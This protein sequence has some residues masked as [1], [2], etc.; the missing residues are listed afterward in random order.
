M[1]QCVSETFLSLFIHNLGFCEFKSDRL[2]IST[3]IIQLQ[4]EKIQFY[5][6]ILI[7]IALINILSYF[8]VN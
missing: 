5:L 2:N 3:T 1:I 4:K 8:N 7:S 6:D